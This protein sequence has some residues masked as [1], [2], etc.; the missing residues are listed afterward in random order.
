M[1]RL[2]QTDSRGFEYFVMNTAQAINDAEM[3]WPFC[4]DILHYRS[5][6]ERLQLP[7]GSFLRELII[8][9]SIEIVTS[10]HP[11]IK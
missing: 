9:L 11:S 10:N 2:L 4:L 3:N 1:P 8:A 6:G 5:G 7:R